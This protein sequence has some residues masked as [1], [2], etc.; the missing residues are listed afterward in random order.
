MTA[1]VIAIMPTTSADTI[2]ASA[3]KA[4]M[5]LSLW[6]LGFPEQAHQMAW[7]CVAD[8][9]D[10]G[11]TFSLAHGLNMG[12]LT[13][14]VL[15]DVEACRAVV[16]EL[17]PLAERYKFHWPLTQAQFLRGWLAIARRGY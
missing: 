1:S 12:S 17:Y 9:R 7:R 4:F 11:H 8:G 10:L 5:R 15:G 16:D 6:G 13:F 14:L 2:P 3:R